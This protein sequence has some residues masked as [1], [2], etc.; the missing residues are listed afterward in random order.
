MIQIDIL[1]KNIINELVKN[2]YTNK[3][4][5]H[6][7]R[8]PK[9]TT[10]EYIDHIFYVLKEGI[11]WEYITN[12]SV[13]GDTIRKKFIQWSNDEIFKD[14]WII[15]LQIYSYMK[16]DFNDLFIDASHIKNILGVEDVGPNHYDRYR[17]GT[18]LSIICDDIGVPLSIQINK[19]NVHD[20]QFIEKNIDTIPIDISSTKYLIGDKGYI[21]KPIRNKIYKKYMVKMITPPRRNQKLK[22]TDNH[23]HKLNKRFIVEISFGWFKKYK[24]LRNRLDKNVNNFYGFV[25]FGAMSIVSKKVLQVFDCSL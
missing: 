8:P 2:K 19:S 7:G 18:K 25:Y 16:L 4:T 17:L 15:M 12:S 5:I 3:N 9:C 10:L 11:G 22:L 13:K 1:S 6:K 24:R 23:K 14:A 20:T 21:G